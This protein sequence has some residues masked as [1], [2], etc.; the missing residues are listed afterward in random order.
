M[1]DTQTYTSY[2]KFKFNA[3]VHRETTHIESTNLLYQKQYYSLLLIN[4]KCI[5]KRFYIKSQQG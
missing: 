2:V 5:N 3:N 4:S 1:K